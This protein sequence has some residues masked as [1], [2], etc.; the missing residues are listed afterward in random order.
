MVCLTETGQ[1]HILF[2]HK[3]GFWQLDDL[4]VK[5]DIEV[6]KHLHFHMCE[7]M[8]WRF[9]QTEIITGKYVAYRI[10]KAGIDNWRK[11]ETQISPYRGT[12]IFDFVSFMLFTEKDYLDDKNTKTNTKKLEA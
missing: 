4:H 12:G 9:S 5:P 11:H 10:N 7:L 1:K 2:K 6:L 3:D 8:A